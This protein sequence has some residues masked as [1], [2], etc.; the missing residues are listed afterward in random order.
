MADDRALVRNAA[1]KKQIEKAGKQ[2]RLERQRELDYVRAVVATPAGRA[3]MWNLLAYCRTFSSVFDPEA[4]SMAFKTGRQ[5]VG[6]FVMAEIS[7]ADPDKFL[8]MMQESQQREKQR[9]AVVDATHRSSPT[10]EE[11]ETG[12]GTAVT[13]ETPDA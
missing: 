4:T 13:E 5:D 2:Q 12:T 3:F 9:N 7:E 6:H 8:L 1:D 11:T 10:D